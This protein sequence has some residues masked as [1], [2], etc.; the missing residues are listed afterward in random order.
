M[1]DAEVVDEDTLVVG[2]CC[3]CVFVEEPSFVVDG[4]LFTTGREAQ[5]YGKEGKHRVMGRKERAFFPMCVSVYFI[6]RT[7][8]GN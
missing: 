4:I 6:R 1:V 8:D 5:G 7:T 2:G 3:V